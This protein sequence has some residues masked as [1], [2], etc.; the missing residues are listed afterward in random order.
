MTIFIIIWSVWFISEIFVSRALRSGNK[1]K[2]GTDKG[3]FRII[4]ITIGI[5]NS[6]GVLSAI[7]LQIPIGST[8]LIPYTGLSLIVLGIIF[9]FISI[10]SLGRL[11]TVK[12]TIR[13]DHKIK[14]D[15]IYR[16]IRHPSYTGSLLS[17]L[18]L[19]LSYNNWISLAVIL[20]PVA[21]AMLH[22]IKIEEKLLV[23]QFGSEYLDYMSRTYR[24]IPYLY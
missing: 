23:E 16:L 21:L 10:L 13:E 18:G 15:G 2:K 20:V 11:F 24:L 1:D 8:Q 14:S 17:F 9:R 5:A 22:R 12:V 7:F 19:G 4:W 3:S 6:L